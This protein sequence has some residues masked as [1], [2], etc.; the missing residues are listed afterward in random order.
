[1]PSSDLHFF[2]YFTGDGTAG[3]HVAVSNDTIRW[4]SLN[5]GVPL[6]VPVLGEQRL[7]RDPHLTRGPDGTF[8]LLWTTGWNDP[9]IGYASSTNLRDWS[10][11]RTLPVMAAFPGTLDCRTPESTYDPLT[12]DFL[13]RWSSSVSLQHGRIAEHRFATRTR[14]FKTFTP[15]FQHSETTPSFRFATLAS[16]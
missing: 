7:M 12:Q 6:L 9:F 10:E 1:M 3:L 4:H 2:A 16:L 13:V 14:D 15:A 8:H 11:Q 5:Q